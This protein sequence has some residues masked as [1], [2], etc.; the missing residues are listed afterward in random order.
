MSYIDELLRDAMRKGEFD[1][2]AGQGRPLP[3]EDNAH[4]PAHLRMAHKL[5]KDNDL[6][7]DWMLEAQTVDAA[8]AAWL[9]DLRA[10][11]ERGGLAEVLPALRERAVRVNRALLTFNLKAP[12]GIPHRPLIEVDAELGRL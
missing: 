5:L 7:P 10:A 8:R 1:G 3:P 11:H 6:S 2:L 12:P 9:A 4:T